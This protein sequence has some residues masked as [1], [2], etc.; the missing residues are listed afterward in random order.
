M[1][2]TAG[3]PSDRRTRRYV[4]FVR[5][6]WFNIETMNP[7]ALEL[8]RKSEKKSGVFVGFLGFLKIPNMIQFE[9]YSRH[10]SIP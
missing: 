2:A 7:C 10:T 3:S 4:L 8:G 5:A 6:N 1:L 9:N